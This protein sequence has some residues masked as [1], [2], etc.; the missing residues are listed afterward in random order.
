MAAAAMR[1]MPMPSAAAFR[2]SSAVRQLKLE[3][4]ERARVIGHPLGGAGES[5]H[6]VLFTT[7]ERTVTD[8]ALGGE[9][10][11]T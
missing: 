5:V 9:E 4:D 1:P 3:L 10:A 7:T 11:L 2:F 8:L 6:G